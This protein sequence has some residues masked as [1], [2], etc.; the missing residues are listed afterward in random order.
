MSTKKQKSVIDNGEH[1]KPKAVT[2]SISENS[3]NKIIELSKL[4]YNESFEDGV[5]RVIKMAEGDDLNA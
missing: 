1:N 5:Q 3:K 2:V 4:G